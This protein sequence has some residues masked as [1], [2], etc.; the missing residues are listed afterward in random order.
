MSYKAPLKD[1]DW[2]L[3]Q[4]VGLSRVSSLPHFAEA[5]D[6]LVDAVLEEAGKFAEGV[7]APLNHSG[8]TQGCRWQDHDVIT[9]DGWVEAYQQFVEAGWMQLSATTEYG[10]QG[11]PYTVGACVNEM[12]KSANMA[13]SLCPLLSHGAI[14]AVTAH[15]SPELKDKYLAKM[16][17]GVWTGTM[18]LTEPQA[19]TDLAALKSKAIPEG[20]HYRVSGQKIFITYGEHGMAENIMHLVLARLPD[21]PAGVRGISLFLVPKFLVNDDGSLGERNDLRC[22]S[23]EEKLGIHGSPTCVMSFGDEG[24]AIGYL[25]GQENQGLACMFTMMNAAR[26]AVGM[27]GYALS[28]RAYQRAL[29]Y[30]M[31]RVQGPAMLATD[32]SSS[33]IV[34]HPDVRRMLM[35]MKSRTEAMRMLAFEAAASYDIAEAAEDEAT[36]KFHQSR[37]ELLTPLVKGWCTETAQLVTYL[38]MQIHGGMGF[39]EETG[40]AQHY[41]DARITTIYEGTTGI[42]ANDLI[43]RKLSRDGGEGLQALSTE[44][45]A[46]ADALSNSDDDRLQLMGAQLSTAN[47]QVVEVAQWLLGNEQQQQAAGAAVPLLMATGTLVGGW[48]QGRSALAAVEAINN[49]ASDKD[50]LEAKIGLAQYFA[51][52]ALPEVAS[53][54]A[55]AIQGGE[56]VDVLS[57][58]QL[59]G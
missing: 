14:E 37:G 20:D 30:A 7:L 50:F 35:D 27:E 44:I 31:D 55:A 34:N 23:I 33:T 46:T 15:G 52:T 54:G 2:A 41:R 38:G 17:E 13:F 16:I 21:A 53:Y 11:L 57:V 4:V 6:D 9:P 12:W 51:G 19:G 1:I 8:D 40:A 28:E 59:Q 49:G 22:V 3:K 24:G 58:E 25:I 10:G 47:E 43:G 48:L 32:K 18:N 29:A 45:A 5:T 42:Q 56:L 39:I 36:R 26:H